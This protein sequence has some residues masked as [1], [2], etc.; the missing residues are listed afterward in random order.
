[1]CGPQ[2]S[3][4]IVISSEAR[5]LLLTKIEEQQIPRRPGAPRNDKGVRCLVRLP[6]T[7]NPCH[8]ERSEKSAFDQELENSRLLVASLLGMTRRRFEVGSRGSN[9]SLLKRKGAGSAYTLVLKSSP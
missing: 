3:P 8:F 1:M 2:Q 7:L 6:Q 9:P 5:N 4:N